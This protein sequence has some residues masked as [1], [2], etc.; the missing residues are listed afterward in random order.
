ME[1]DEVITAQPV[2]GEKLPNG[3]MCLAVFN[4]EKFGIVLAEH[5]TTL[6]GPA[7]YITWL[8]NVEQGAR[9]TTGGDYCWSRSKAVES[10]L[11]RVK[12]ELR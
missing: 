11:N 12:G 10:F 8:F 5:P 3:A 9:S 7:K 6:N 1:G 4:N 2:P